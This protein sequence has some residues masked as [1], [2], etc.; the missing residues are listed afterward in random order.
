MMKETQLDELLRAGPVPERDPEYWE[1][2]PHAVTARLRH[3]DRERLAAAREMQSRVPLP[4]LRFRRAALGVG[5]ACACLLLGLFICPWKPGRDLAEE[6][7]RAVLQ[8]CFRETSALFPRQLRALVADSDGFGLV[9]AEQAN[10]PTDVPIYVRVTSREK[11]Q[12]A[13]TF[14]GQQITLAGRKWEIL[15]DAR[16]NIIVIG[17]NSV[18]SN[19]KPTLPD[20]SVRIEARR[21]SI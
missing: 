15:L 6:R 7:R 16:G 12:S 19:S 8:R 21:L 20:P 1:Q 5:L 4:W 2:F 14:S 17:E 13:I 3:N 18:W 10:L 9:L 11:S